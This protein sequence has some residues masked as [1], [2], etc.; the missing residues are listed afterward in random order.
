[1]K[2]WML[3]CLL[4]SLIY[5]MSVEAS[6]L[7]QPLTA[8]VR[9]WNNARLDVLDCAVFMPSID[10]D[11][12]LGKTKKLMVQLKSKGFRPIIIPYLNIEENTFRS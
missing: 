1:M 5:T 12:G 2:E 10:T 11:L 6:P 3:F 9:Y 8:Q 7:S 4:C